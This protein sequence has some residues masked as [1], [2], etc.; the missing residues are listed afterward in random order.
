MV[1]RSFESHANA[2]ATGSALHSLLCDECNNWF[3]YI[4]TAR[5]TGQ[6][7]SFIL[8][9]D[10]AA[11]NRARF[12]ARQNLKQILNAT[13]FVRPCPRCGHIPQQMHRQAKWEHKPILRNTALILVGLGWAFVLPVLHSRERNSAGRILSELFTLS[14][15]FFSDPR[16]SLFLT[17]VLPGISLLILWL[18]LAIRYRPNDQPLAARLAL[19][20]KFSV[21][22]LLKTDPDGNEILVIEATQDLPPG[23]ITVKAAVLPSVANTLVDLS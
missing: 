13:R 15:S 18:A 21:P 8:P 6:G 11:I 2:T 14:P 17:L 1:L 4:V 16:L 22:L 23:D 3:G 19:A 10:K 7:K 20:K 9:N 5:A 12:Y